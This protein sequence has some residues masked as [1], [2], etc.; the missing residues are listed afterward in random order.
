MNAQ[1]V[2]QAL[3]VYNRPVTPA[4]V[5]YLLAPHLPAMDSA[6]ILQRL[7]NMHFARKDSGW[8]H[9]HQVDREFA[10]NLL[11]EGSPEDTVVEKGGLKLFKNLW[12]LLDKYPDLLK[13]QET[14]NQAVKNENA[15]IVVG[16]VM[17][18]QKLDASLV[19]KMQQEG[20]FEDENFLA[21]LDKSF[22]IP[23]I[24][25]RYALNNRAADYFAQAR[26]P[27]AEWKKLDDL[28]AQLAEF[29]LRCAAGDYD[30]AASVLLEIDYDYLF[31][32]GH[33]RL[34]I[35]LHEKLQGRINDAALSRRNIGNLGQ[36]L[37]FI[38]K[39]REAISSF[40]KALKMAKEAKS[41]QAESVWLV[42]LGNRY[43]E[44]GETRIAA[45]YFEQALVIDRAIGNRIGEAETLVNIG[46]IY[47]D[48]QD[49][50]SGIESLQ[51]VAQIADEFSNQSLQQYGRLEL[52]QAYLFQNDLMNSRAIIEAALEFNVPMNN[53]D[54]S[55][56]HGIIALRQGDEVAARGAFLRAIGQAD[57]IL[58]KTAEYYSALDAKG[59]AL[60]GLA[61]CARDDGR[62]TVDHP[63]GTL[64][65]GQSSVV[66]RQQAIETFRKARKIAPHAGVVKRVLRL[67]D[68]LA[69]CEG[70]EI[71]KEV[72]QAVEGKE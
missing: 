12:D 58:S 49:Y 36:A 64:R 10:Y 20:I 8:F 71:L 38:G 39:I 62:Q 47:I 22:H 37:N 46:H 18:F 30:T 17:A 4:A 1:K 65:S 6:P 68:E 55:A 11:P 28:A 13:N 67:F 48:L 50:D 69:K 41:Q 34:A 42:N 35:D 51:Q 19:E 61:L 59:L 56:L 45:E 14:F 3:A 72:R 5:D 53:H 63:T 27:R 32:W 40:E 7:A 33:Y 2:M 52:A 60:C 31:I 23:P 26:K 54:A 21:E 25:S 43:A 66:Y 29:D 57:E 24:W 44:L 9:L 70:G 15:K 16:S